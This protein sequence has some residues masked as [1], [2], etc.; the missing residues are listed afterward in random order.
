VKTQHLWTNDVRPGALFRIPAVPDN[1]ML[2]V[3]WSCNQRCAFCYQPRAQA[4][5]G[6]PEPDIL[7]GIVKELARWG[8]A[9]VL[10]L[11]GEPLLHPRIEEALEIGAGLG[12]RQRLVTNGSRLDAAR[13]RRL[14]RMG[15]GI[16]VS[17]L[18][19]DART[20]DALAGTSGSFELALAALDAIRAADG[21]AWIQYSPTRLNQ[22]Q[23]VPLADLIRR[24]LGYAAQ[25]V[26][27]N[28]LLPFGRARQVRR[29]VL[30]GEEG[31]W[32]AL[33]EVEVLTAGGWQVRVESVPRCW[34]R[35]QA[36]RDCLSPERTQA[37]IATLRTCWMAISQ[38]A[39]DPE[40]RIKLCPGGPPVGP[41]IMTASA[42]EVWLRE[43]VLEERRQLLFLPTCC[44]DYPARSICAEFYDCGGGCRAA[45]GIMPHA[46]DPLAMPIGLVASS[47]PQGPASRAPGPEPGVG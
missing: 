47:V 46:P 36:A 28:R 26:D 1:V 7:V 27:V 17:L 15:L 19:S 25:F 14:A 33:L 5:R 20:H 24:R 37:I 18:G 31:W 11:G 44:V 6:H 12:L 10:Y 38:L 34:I 13:A 30:L 16:G 4:R 32:Q 21:F 22:G 3:T 2:D 41:S 9:E 43:P 40:G 23:L 29:S 39:L 8:V 45:A 35:R 42:E